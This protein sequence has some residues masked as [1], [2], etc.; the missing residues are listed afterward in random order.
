[1][2][3]VTIFA[4]RKLAVVGVGLSGLAT[5]RSL[6]EGGADIVM[7][8]DNESGRAQAAEAGF[9][10]QDLRPTDFGAFTT[11]VL[12]PG[13]PLTHPEPHWSVKK[14]RAAGI[15]VIG[16]VELFFR[17]RAA[18]GIDC[19]VIAIT[20]TNGKST[21]TALTAH[22]LES[23]GR[24][25]ALGGNIGK[26]V[27]DLAPFA[28]VMT[29][30]LELS[31]YQIDLTPSLKPDAA[32]LLNITPDHLDR[33]GS[34]AGY[35]SVKARVFAQLE[36]DATAV[37][38]IDDAPCQAIADTLQGPYAVKRIAID[39]TVQNGIWAADATLME[40][41]GGNEVARADLT[42]IGSLRGAHNWQNAATAYALARA[43]GIEPPALQK[44][45]KS[46]GGLA[47]RM[48]Q[49]AR[50]GTVLFVNDSK[51][52][53]AD[54]AGKALGSF[55]NIFW[56]VGGVAKDGG[57]QGLEPFYPRIARAYLIGDAAEA[58]AG[59][60]G[61]AVPHIACGTLDRAVEQAAED[62]SLSN[63]DEPVVLLSPACASFDQYANFAMRGDA[64]RELV[65]QRNGVISLA[66]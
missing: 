37:I 17:A 10:V 46:F 39:R 49:V 14:A 19:K 28:P 64:F 34:L 57:L 54:A 15:E 21:T 65:M 31:S 40:M 11:L 60:F 44:G 61:D 8:D 3:P 33:H 2:I 20:G 4:G 29:Y 36:A 47:H 32:A 62:A 7:W 27:L 1:M 66:G 26:A 25:V 9:P 5:A 58:F 43:Q 16:D 45:L 41:E 53:N 51:A 55:D 50:E 48:E 38:G 63:A 22:L 56:I 42:G 59:Q 24:E 18:S 52:T 6:Q 13:I 30:V 23:A 35:A 12:A